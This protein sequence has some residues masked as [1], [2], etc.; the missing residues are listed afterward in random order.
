MIAERN[1]EHDQRGRAR[2][3]MS[4]ARLTML[5]KPCSGT[6]L[7]LMTGTPSRS[8]SRARSAITC[9]RSGTTLT[10]THLAARALEQLEHPD[11]LLGRQRDVEVI[12][13]LARGDLGGLVERAEQRQ[14]AVA[15][16]I[17]GRAVVDEA[18]DLVAEL[19]VLENLVGD[20]PAELAGAGDQD[21]LEADAGAPAALEHL[22]HQL[23]RRVGQRDVQ[24]EEDRPDRPATPRSAPRPWPRR[25]AK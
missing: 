12:D 23:A 11:V 24:H 6:S 1:G 3:A 20:Q 8:S 16:M 5:L 19:A 15:E 18:D 14:A 13:R 7:M 17:A 4:I 2:C 25:V 21:P 22:A 9:S 10:S